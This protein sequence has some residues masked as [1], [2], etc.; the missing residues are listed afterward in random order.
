[1][2]ISKTYHWTH[3]TRNENALNG[4][5]QC[6]CSM[7]VSYLFWNINM[8]IKYFIKSALE[9]CSWHGDGSSEWLWWGFGLLRAPCSS[10]CLCEGSLREM[11]L[12]L[13]SAGSYLWL[14]WFIHLAA[15][16]MWAGVW[17]H[18]LRI[19]D[20][21]GLICEIINSSCFIFLIMI[22]ISEA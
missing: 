4:F 12:S 5:N 7:Q 17:S 15:W 13:A 1:M 8:Y 20:L 10:P 19:L 22:L 2:S 21:A 3:T 18:L 16:A 14:S 11:R 6:Q 9:K